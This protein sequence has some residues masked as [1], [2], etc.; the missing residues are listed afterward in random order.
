MVRRNATTIG[1]C[2]REKSKRQILTSGA[3]PRVHEDHHGQGF[4]C[5]SSFH[6]LWSRKRQFREGR[7]WVSIVFS[8][9][10]AGAAPRSISFLARC[11]PL[12]GSPLIIPS[13]CSSHLDAPATALIV[14][15]HAEGV[16]GEA[17][18]ARLARPMTTPATAPGEA[19]GPDLERLL[20]RQLGTARPRRC[21]RDSAAVR[22]PRNCRSTHT[23]CWLKGDA[24]AGA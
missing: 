15:R 18:G 19:A 17:G 12:A 5:P 3:V 21:V 4:A 9:R 13:S 16:D 14:L 6:R 11:T 23:A 24:E 2:R 22:Q 1:R 10:C 7:F 20:G 8:T